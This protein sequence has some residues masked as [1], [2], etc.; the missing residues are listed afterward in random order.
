MSSV[1]DMLLFYILRAISMRFL[2]EFLSTSPEETK[3]IF[4]SI[5]GFLHLSPPLIFFLRKVS[6][7]HFYCNHKTQNPYVVWRGGGGVGSNNFL[8]P[9]HYAGQQRS[10]RGRKSQETELRWGAEHQNQVMLKL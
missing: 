6:I 8:S 3:F 10:G 5:M 4:C 2:N 1:W 7:K 9:I